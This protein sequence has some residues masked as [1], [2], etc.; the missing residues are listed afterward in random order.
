VTS[1][2]LFLF[3]L[4]LSISYDGEDTLTNLAIIILMYFTYSQLWIYVV[5]KSVYQDLIKKEKRIWDKT[6]RFDVPAAHS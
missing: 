6:V 3:E 2:I 4:F 5:I 1:L